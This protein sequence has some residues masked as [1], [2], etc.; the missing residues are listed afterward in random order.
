MGGL[1]LLFKQPLRRQ[2]SSILRRNSMQL[3]LNSCF[4]SKI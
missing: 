1:H 4:R 2:K 3:L